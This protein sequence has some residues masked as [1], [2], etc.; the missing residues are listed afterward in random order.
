MLGFWSLSSIP[1][2]SALSF[3]GATLQLKIYIADPLKISIM[4]IMVIGKYLQYFNFTCT[5]A[6]Q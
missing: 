5:P 1:D 4:V 2:R 3:S 6:Q